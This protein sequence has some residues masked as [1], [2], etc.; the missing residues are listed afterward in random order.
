MHTHEVCGLRKGVCN[1][2]DCGM[3]P[4]EGN[5]SMLAPP[6]FLSVDSTACIHRADGF[7]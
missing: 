4:T 3:W 6:C 7:S 1:K 2:C 5:T